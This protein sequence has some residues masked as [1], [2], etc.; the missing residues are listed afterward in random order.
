M[1]KNK[2]GF[3][4][5]F[6]FLAFPIG[7]ALFREFDFESFTFRKTALGFLYLITFIAVIVLMLKKNKKSTG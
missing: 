3:N 6:A 1:M 7:L 5:V 2:I 4:L